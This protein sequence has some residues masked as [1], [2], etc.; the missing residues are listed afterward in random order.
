MNKINL[1]EEIENYTTR[2]IVNWGQSF[3]EGSGV[4]I[5]EDGFVATAAHVIHN[6][7]GQ[8]ANEVLIRKKGTGFKKYEPII[9]SLQ[10][11]LPFLSEPVIIDLSLLKPI[12][13]G[14]KD[15]FVEIEDD[16]RV[17]IDCLMAGFPQE[18]NLPFNIGKKIDKTKIS[19]GNKEQF[20]L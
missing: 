8:V 15:D 16:I 11:N 1:C 14:F 2:I 18:M 17:G 10:V 3:S 12:D 4:V 5:T 20:K 6:D 7:L 9:N 19:I 13:S